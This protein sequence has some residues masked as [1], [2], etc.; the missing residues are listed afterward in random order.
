MMSADEEIALNVTQKLMGTG[1]W[2]KDFI[3]KIGFYLREGKVSSSD[4]VFLIENQ[5]NE[6]NEV[7]E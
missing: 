5:R 2:P 6:K 7:K 1:Q 4:I 3:D